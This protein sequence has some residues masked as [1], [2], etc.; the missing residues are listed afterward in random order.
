MR[1]SD[2]SSITWTHMTA[3]CDTEHARAAALEKVER[4]AGDVIGVDSVTSEVLKLHVVADVGGLR[5]LR[6]FL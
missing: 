6:A 4:D 5:A 2:V 1:D 3:S